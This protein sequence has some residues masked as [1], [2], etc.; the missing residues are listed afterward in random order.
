MLGGRWSVV[1]VSFLV[2]AGLSQPASAAQGGWW[3]EDDAVKA[4]SESR[5]RARGPSGWL[6]VLYRDYLS[7]VDGVRTCRFEPTCGAYCRE[8]IGRHGPLLGWIMGCERAIRYH[9]DTIAYPL[10]IIGG[11]LRLLDPVSDN[12]FWF[13]RPAARSRRERQQP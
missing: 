9:D 13:R 1:G 5:D 4:K 7:Q 12:D 8:A 10:T 6:M 2:L 3:P 11:E